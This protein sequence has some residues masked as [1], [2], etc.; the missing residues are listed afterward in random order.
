MALVEGNGNLYSFGNNRHS[1]LGVVQQGNS[2]CS[3]V[4]VN[5]PW[6]DEIGNKE[7]HTQNIVSGGNQNFII[8]QNNKVFT[9]IK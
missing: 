6:K 8:L 7:F 4:L 3:P 9:I 1:Q 5:G 2:Q